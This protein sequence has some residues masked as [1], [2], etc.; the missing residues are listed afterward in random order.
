MAKRTTI[1]PAGRWGRLGRCVAT[2]TLAI[3]AGACDGLFDTDNPN[4]LVQEDLEKASATAALVNGAEATVARG[5]ADAVLAVSVPT[6]ELVWVGSYDAGRELDNGYLKN[7]VNEFSNNEAWGTFAEG[8]FMADEAI[9]LLGQFDAEGT[10]RNRAALARSYLYGATAY[11]YAAD[12][13]DEFVLSDRKEAQPPIAA[14]DMAR[15]YDKA[16]EYATSGLAVARAIGSS[17]LEASLLAARAR[18]HFARGVWQKLN[19]SGSTPTAPLVS[20]ASADADAAAV[21]AI[22]QPDWKL[23]FKYSATSVSNQLGSWINSRQEFRVDTI[24]GVPRSSGTRVESVALLDPIDDVPDPALNAAL[25]ELG[26]LSTTTELYPPFTVTSAREMRLILAES[27]LESGD[28]TDFATHINAVR[29][30]DGLTSWS[31]QVPAL[32]MLIHARR[33]NLFLQGRRLADM[34]RFGVQDARWLDASDAATE[35]GT[36][37]PIADMEQKSNCHLQPGGCGS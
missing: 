22:V 33:V 1:V 26:L 13:W 29:S 15:L 37:F 11:T 9:R 20:T 18:A 3:F 24:Y 31:G 34:Y 23:Q 25:T 8:R 2:V 6:D 32:D 10:L 28:L 30:L 4:E 7:P 21:L 19:P 17:D 14:A 5:A 36:F 16:I 27:A 35:P 12:W